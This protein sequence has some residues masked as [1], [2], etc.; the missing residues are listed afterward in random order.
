MKLSEME[1]CELEDTSD[2]DEVINTSC[3]HSSNS[4]KIK[5]A[6]TAECP[7]G[8]IFILSDNDVKASSNNTA[9]DAYHHQ[10][11]NI[12][13][14]SSSSRSKC[15]CLYVDCLSCS[16]KLCVLVDRYRNDR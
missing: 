16:H 9:T 4:K 14:L 6:F 3:L 11:I 1:E 15:V 8:D 13:V 12:G 7:C 10:H 2:D 5:L